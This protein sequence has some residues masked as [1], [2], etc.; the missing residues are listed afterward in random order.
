[1]NLGS[2][3]FELKAMLQIPGR[4]VRAMM[5]LMPGDIVCLRMLEDRRAE[6][7]ARKHE[8]ETRDRADELQAQL[9]KLDADYE[10]IVAA[11]VLI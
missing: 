9:D 11:A 7:E 8:A 2:R 6:L 4:T 3:N 1:L 10:S 5:M